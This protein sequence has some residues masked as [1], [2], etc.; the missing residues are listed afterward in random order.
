MIICLGIWFGP[1]IIGL[2]LIMTGMN[3]I[4]TAWIRRKPRKALITENGA[5]LSAAP[6]PMRDRYFDPFGDSELIGVCLSIYGAVGLMIITEGAQQLKHAWHHIEKRN[7]TV[8][9]NMPLPWG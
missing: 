3:Q 8:A 6:A 5:V 2:L 1:L 4:G 9:Q 7:F